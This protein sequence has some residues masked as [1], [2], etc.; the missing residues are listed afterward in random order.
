MEINTPKLRFAT[1]LDCEHLFKPTST[2]KKCGCFMKV[3]V[4]LKGSECP[5]GKWGKIETV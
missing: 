1:C 4:R 5:I 2:C 3:K